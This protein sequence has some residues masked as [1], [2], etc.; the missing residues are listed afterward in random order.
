MLKV[1]DL[2]VKYDNFVAVNDV[3]LTVSD[4]EFVGIIGPNGSGKSTLLRAI[5]G[6]YHPQNGEVLLD[7]KDIYKMKPKE[8]ARNIS[9]VPEEVDTTFAFTVKEIV[10]M[11]RYPYQK[12]FL[13]EEEEGFKIAEERLKLLEIEGLSERYINELSSGEKQRVVIARA[14]CQQSKFILL[15][16]PTSHLDISHQIEILDIIKRLNI[17]KKVTVIIVMHDLNLASEYCDRILLLRNGAIYKEGNP[18]E[19]MTYQNIEYVYKTVVVVNKNPVS[20]KPHILSV[21][22]WDK[23]SNG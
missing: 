20:G 9:F 21:P 3:N 11:G 4:Y 6:F 22:Q 10:L 16:E 23:T 1:N 2:V 17:E 5:S 7:E 8:R 18:E 14:L 13:R 19:V 12:Q 15:D